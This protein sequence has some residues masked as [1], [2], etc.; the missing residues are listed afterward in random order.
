MLRVA[1][2]AVALAWSSSTALADTLSVRAGE[3]L[4]VS[5][6]DKGATVLSRE[7]A[8]SLSAFEAEGLANAQALVVPP[9]AKTVPPVGLDQT[10]AA[11]PKIVTKQLQITFRNVPG[12]NAGT[13][14]SFLTL[15]NGYDHFV[16]YR[17]I[18]HRGDASRPSDVCDVLPGRTGFEHWPYKLNSVE[19]SDFQ[20][21]DLAGGVECQ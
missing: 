11:P 8:P 5:I 18:M 2:V 13:V 16:R 19:L 1:V 14:H 3:S 10:N 6:S 12:V 9:S 21:V 20:L 4:R 15:E 7:S 17:A